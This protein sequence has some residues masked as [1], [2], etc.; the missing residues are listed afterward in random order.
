MMQ[1][2]PNSSVVWEH[3]STSIFPSEVPSTLG[4]QHLR[5]HPRDTTGKQQLQA[6]VSLTC[7][8]CIVP[9]QQFSLKSK[10]QI[11]DAKEVDIDDGENGDYVGGVTS[12]LEIFSSHRRCK[13]SVSPITPW[14]SNGFFRFFFSA[15]Q[16]ICCKITWLFAELRFAQLRSLI[17][18][19]HL[20]RK[21]SLGTCHD[22]RNL[23]TSLVPFFVWL[24]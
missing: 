1:K 17:P 7:S 22:N 18:F 24:I 8:L 15:Y 20:T 19:L 16:V 5:H 2:H 21:R 9:M 13:I 23:T 10:T 3:A 12:L 4:R 11:Q 6:L 14:L